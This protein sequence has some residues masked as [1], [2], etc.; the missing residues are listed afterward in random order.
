MSVATY[1]GVVENGQIRLTTEAGLP[2]NAKVYMIVPGMQD[3]PVARVASPR[4]ADP[5]DAA[6]FTM[7]IVEEPADDALLSG[8]LSPACT[9]SPSNT[10][11][12]CNL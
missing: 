8:S 11:Q 2:E 12:P 1:E 9:G 10:V 5:R 7:E 6:R 4:L 3:I